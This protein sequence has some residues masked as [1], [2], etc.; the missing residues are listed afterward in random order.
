MQQVKKI[1]R[2]I[3][4]NNSFNKL[5]SLKEFIEN[6]TS[7]VKCFYIDGVL[8]YKHSTVFKQNTFKKIE[9]LIILK[10]HSLEKGLLHNITR[11]QFGK[12]NVIELCQL[13][14]RE[15]I[16]INKNR[17]Q[18]SAAYLTICAYYELHS[19]NNIDISSYY[20]KSDYDEFKEYSNSNLSSIKK[21]QASSYFEES[22][23]DFSNFS[24][25]R[26][27]VR[28]FT[29][30]KIQFNTIQNVIELAK[31]APS[32]C[33]RQP[34]I[35]YYVDDKIIIDSIF[36]IQGGLKG[37]SD[38][39]SNLLV[40]ACDRNYF[41]TVGERNQLYIDGG[42]F[43]MNLLYALHYY[44]IAACPAHWGLNIDS[45]RKAIKLLNMSKSEKIICLVAIGIPKHNFNT[46]L[47]LR[48][49]GEEILKRV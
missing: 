48:R 27:S 30:E 9:A 46:T 22:D 20:S 15:E 41:Y 7:L 1:I 5:R 21:Q 10:Y 34:V 6:F 40:V 49:S 38:E 36:K 39:I 35:V 32:V 28:D 26:S 2:F 12:Q 4:G 23:K 43:L 11:Y 45:D 13:L 24:N 29:N 42:I 16:I 18:I 33:N 25:S 17:T 31:N 8:Y 44:K 37:Y 3:L 14:K 19:E 47:S